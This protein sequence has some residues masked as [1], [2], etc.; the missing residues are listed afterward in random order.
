MGK[1]KT[2]SRGW[3]QR[4]F[5][6]RRR[7][8]TFSTR[9]NL[10][11]KIPLG[12]KNEGILLEIRSAST[13]S[14]SVRRTWLWLR[15]F[16]KATGSLRS[17]HPLRK[18]TLLSRLLHLFRPAKFFIPISAPPDHEL[19]QQNPSLG[20]YGRNFR[21]RNMLQLTRGKLVGNRGN[22]SQGK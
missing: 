17:F 12:Q 14:S 11:T 1:D 19:S 15:M 7:R 3:E 6:I 10:N 16:S 21:E 2:P 8:N 22:F 4:L 13:S 18:Y 9:R 5:K 20:D